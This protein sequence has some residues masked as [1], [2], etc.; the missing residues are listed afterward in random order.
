[1]SEAFEVFATAQSADLDSK[2]LCLADELLEIIKSGLKSSW[3]VTDWG[4]DLGKDGFVRLV[5]PIHES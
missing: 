4:P 5:S 3:R 2:V 1:M